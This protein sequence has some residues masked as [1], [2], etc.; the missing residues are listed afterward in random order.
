MAMSAA[1]ITGAEGE[2]AAPAA[3]R[4]GGFRTEDAPRSDLLEACVRCG[5]CMQVCPTYQELGIEPDSPR[6]RV[7]LIKAVHDGLLPL[8]DASFAKHIY[9]CLDCRACETA[10]PMGVQVGRLIEEARGEIRQAAP[11]ERASDGVTGL[12]ASLL[13]DPGRTEAAARAVAV[14][15]RLGLTRLARSLG[16][17]RVLPEHVRKMERHMPLL[18]LTSARRR[19]GPVVPA[20]GT[21]RGRVAL[22]HGCV[23][24]V[25]FAE[26]TEATARVLARNGWEVV[27][28]QEQTCCG[29]LHVH[30]GDRD[31]GKAMARRNIAA[32]EAA[33]ADAYV[34]NAA[35]CGSAMKEYGILLENDGEWAARAAA[36][37]AKV[38][39]VQEFLAAEGWEPPRGAFPARAVYQ[40]A[41]HLAHAQGIRQQPR[42]LL[43]SVPGLELVEMPDSDRCCG[44]AG[45]Y[46]V[47]HPHIAEPLLERKVADVPEGV[48]V[49]VTA[50]P[51][52]HLQLARGLAEAGR[53][54]RVMHVMEVLDA[55][56]RA[57][58]GAV[59]HGR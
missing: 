3:P 14:A 35:G 2:G 48:D 39:D 37:S 18:P 7:F 59:D 55:A 27:L 6:G 19:L 31:T 44:S 21:R 36:F 11:S 45:V 38:R 26:V 33:D 40:D 46:N 17:T 4:H 23:M 29:A 22:L 12:L 13:P 42:Q 34:V 1:P 5:A 10:C 43:R 8:E 49:L 28:P 32:F 58:E 20:R 52:C 57:E 16:L 50:N 51:G 24:N 53:D 54:V 47:T 56:Y 30:A 25:V 15:Q 9:Q 41:C